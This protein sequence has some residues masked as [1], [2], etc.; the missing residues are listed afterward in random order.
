MNRHQLLLI[1]LSG[2]LAFNGAGFAQ[3]GNDRKTIGQPHPHLPADES[4][5]TTNRVGNKL[6]L[7]AEADAFTFIVFGD[8]TGGPAEGVKILALAVRDTNLI[9]P[10]LVMTVGDLVEGYNDTPQWL[11]Q[12]RE[13]RG[14]MDDLLMPWFPVAGNHDVY[15]RGQGPRPDGEHEANYEM[16]FGPLWYAFE[17]KRCWF[18]ALYSDEGNPLTGAKG[19]SQPDRQTM[20][21]AQL[22]WLKVT[23]VKAKEAEHIFVFLHHPRWLGGGYGD[24]WNRVHAA[25]AGAGNV[26]AVFAGHIHHMRH[27]GVRDGIEYVTLATV[28]GGQSGAA[29]S[30][31]YLHQFHL[32]T[33]R[34]N[35]IALASIPVG[36]VMDVRRLTGEVSED[37]ERLAGVRPAFSS[38]LPLDATGSTAAELTASITNPARSPIEVTFTPL[39]ADSRWSFAP[40]H[41]HKVLNPGEAMEFTFLAARGGHALDETF[42]SPQLTVDI[43]LL[44]AGLR[45]PIPTSTTDVP[46]RADLAPPPVPE[47]EV[48]AD[49]DGAGAFIAVESDRVD[50]PDGPLTLECW[51]NGDDFTGR[52][53]LV[54]KTENS[55]YGFFVSDSVPSFYLFLSGMY[56]EV[57]APGAMLETGRWH[58]IAGVFDGRQTRLYLDGALIKAVDRVGSRRRNDFPLMIGADVDGR[59]RPTSYFDGRIDAVRLSSVAR[60]SGERFT[61]SRRPAADADTLLLFNMDAKVGPWLFDES[62]RAVHAISPGPVTLS[63]D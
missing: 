48:A 44:A 21:D 29:P 16:H 19:F 60:Y 57:I 31:G 4:R 47:V 8:R 32:V 55:E 18:I 61:P 34:K 46:M 11:E 1:A 15:W 20:S 53:G 36:E 62:S 56:V 51:F 50:L 63:S 2:T 45:Y 6:Y 49:F 37:A 41:A 9:E 40:D 13:F 25:L 7:P 23:L 42:R 59:G 3:D 14:I 22:D 24:D 54:G 58:H 5:F 28:G 30:A 52:R 26:T 35:Q 33:V 27:D 10:D 38:H 17:H 12:M 43:D 39:S